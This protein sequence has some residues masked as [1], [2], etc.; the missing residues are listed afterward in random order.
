MSNQSRMSRAFG[1][2]RGQQALRRR[3]PFGQVR[4]EHRGEIGDAERLAADEREPDDH[5]LG[6][7]VEDAAEHDAEGALPLAPAGPRG[8]LALRATHLRDEIVADRERGAAH[9]QPE[10]DSLPAAGQVIR[11]LDEVERHRTDEHTGAEAH[12]GA[13]HPHAD[14]E[15]HRDER[16]DEQ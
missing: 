16:A 8:V 1:H 13:D 3:D 7:A 14:V 11:V 2:P 9:D 4:E 10:A 6:D 12:D 15:L 5:R